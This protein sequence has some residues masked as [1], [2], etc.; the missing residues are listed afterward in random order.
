MTSI[1]LRAGILKA[2]ACATTLGISAFFYSCDRLTPVPSIPPDFRARAPSGNEIYVFPFGRLSMTAFEALRAEFAGVVPADL[3]RIAM[4]AQ[5]LAERNG[6]EKPVS[7]QETTRCVRALFSPAVSGA[8]IHW[9]TEFAKS[10]F[11]FT[12]LDLLRQSYN[13]AAK[14]WAIEWNP[15]LAREYRIPIT[16]P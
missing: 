8:E 12:S 13:D 11:A 1:R 16:S 4:G 6:A 2:V 9:A 14:G 7:L 10:R 15:T 3:V 5:W